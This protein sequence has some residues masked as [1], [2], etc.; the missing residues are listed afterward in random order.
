MASQNQLAGQYR[1]QQA[2]L[3]ARTVRDVLQI[4]LALF[5]PANARTSW[6][7]VRLAI[8]NLVANQGLLSGGL[9]A[10]YY[11]QAR[12][13]AGAS[14]AF[15]PTPAPLPS[16]ELV[17]ATQDSTGLGAFL[18]AV[19]TGQTQ[20]QARKNAGVQLT[21]ATSRLVLDVGRQTV[22]Q[23]VRQDPE[24]LGW[25][26]VTDAHPCAFCAMLAGRGPV[27]R[28]E[29][30][31]AFQ[32]HNHCACVAAPVFSRDEAWLGHAADLAEQWQQVTRGKS[33]DAARIAWR[34]HWEGRAP[35][36]TA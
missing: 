11:Q 1:Q 33:G 18:H 10:T 36:P 23:A 20:D 28:S 17:A 2:L 5:D 30:T 29:K 7:A 15:T 21:G 35:T 8:S 25:A 26:R 4:F 31:A 6:P 3:R 32:A 34:Q 27:Y 14:G 9:A 22:Q 19:K 16:P 24:A 13:F 12:T